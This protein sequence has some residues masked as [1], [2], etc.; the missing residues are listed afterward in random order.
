MKPPDQKLAMAVLRSLY[1]LRASLRPALSPV[2]STAFR[3]LPCPLPCRRIAGSALAWLSSIYK[4][5]I[6]A[7]V[8]LV[9]IAWTWVTWQL[10]RIR[11][12][13]MATVLMMLA[14]SGML[15]LAYYWP[16]DRAHRRYG[17]DR[18]LTS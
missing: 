16:A 2:P 13:P 17:V 3:H 15:A 9:A 11:K 4:G 1:P 7:A 12:R 8:A 14:V 10:L 5:T 6:I 18:T